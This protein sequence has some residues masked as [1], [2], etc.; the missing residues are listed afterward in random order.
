MFPGNAIPAL[1]LNPVALR[2]IA[3]FVPA[4]DLP[5]VANNYLDTRQT[6]QRNNQESAR[7]DH[8]LTGKDNVFEIGRA[9][10]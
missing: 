9:H 1:R 2:L 7:I 5:G 3:G 8:R 4:P 10:V 6:R